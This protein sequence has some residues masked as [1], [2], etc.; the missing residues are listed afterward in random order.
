MILAVG[1][2][3]RRTLHNTMERNIL[4]TLMEIKLFSCT[5]I[6]CISNLSRIII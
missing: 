3:L 4:A 1:Y 5:L 2:W 6:D